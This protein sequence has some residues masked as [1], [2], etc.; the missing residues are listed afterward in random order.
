MARR[1]PPISNKPDR[2]VVQPAST[3]PDPTP[4]LMAA[5]PDP[6][7]TKTILSAYGLRD[8][9]QSDRNLQAMAGEPHERRQLADILPLLL[10]SIARTACSSSNMPEP[11]S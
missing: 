6:G 10:D 5:E 9:E 7:Q 3:R 11:S 8:I 1:T 4:V 2:V